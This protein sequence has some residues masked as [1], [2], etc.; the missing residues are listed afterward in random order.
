EGHYVWHLVGSVPL[1]SV[2]RTLGWRDPQ[3][4]ADHISGALLLAFEIAI[5]A[6]LIRLGLSGYQFFEDRRGKSAVKREID[7]E[8]KFAKEA[9][10]R[11][12][13]GEKPVARQSSMRDSFGPL[14]MV[15]VAVI[16]TVPV[17]MTVG[18]R[19]WMDHWLARLPTELSVGEAHLP[20][21]WLH[22]VP[23]L[24]AVI[25]L[26]GLIGNLIPM[27]RDD[28]N[29]DMVRSVPTVAVAILTYLLVLALLTLT[30]AVAS[31]ALLHLKLAASHPRIPPGSRPLTA[32]NAY[33][34]S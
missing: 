17:V 28:A 22:A 18:K 6:P 8:Q 5:I 24:I 26:I 27:L 32:I 33:A 16:F 21:H 29:P 11:L 25:G 9:M 4:S 12:K 23:P 19:S 1:L 30:A 3:P 10:E 15:A 2:P 34:W 7:R 20:L 14:A 31:L 13:R